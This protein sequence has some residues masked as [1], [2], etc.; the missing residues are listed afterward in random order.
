MKKYHITNSSVI[1]ILPIDFLSN[2]LYNQ[3]VSVIIELP[4][5][6]IIPNTWTLL[7]V[8]YM[9]TYM[10][11]FKNAKVIYIDGYNVT[12]NSTKILNC[13][14]CKSVIN[15]FEPYYY[16]SNYNGDYTNYYDT[17]NKIYCID[18]S[19]TKYIN[20]KQYKLRINHFKI[21]ICDMCNI[22]I[23]TFNFYHNTLSN[24][25]LCEICGAK[26]ENKQIIETKKLHFIENNIIDPIGYTFGSLCEWLPIILINEFDTQLI[27]NLKLSDNIISKRLILKHYS[28][29][30]Y[31]I[32]DIYNLLSITTLMYL[33][34]PCSTIQEVL[35][36]LYTSNTEINNIDNID[37]NDDI[38]IDI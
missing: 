12:R 13:N 18:C 6:I 14:T 5:N 30:R 32:C 15:L 29:N 24:Y 21:Y 9:P 8:S 26:K 7:T 34:L 22:P 38:Y 11:M 2:G 3:L 28:Q 23:E 1:P 16:N 10:K 31:A 4:N 36:E 19:G 33:E 27:K 37:I 20:N 35:N 25:D 17:S